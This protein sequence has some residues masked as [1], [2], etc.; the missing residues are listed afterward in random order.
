MKTILITGAGSGFGLETA[1]ALAK[2][3]HR[4][5]ATTH[6]T[7]QEQKV[8]EIAKQQSLKLE[9]FTLDIT[10]EED[11]QKI[12][13]ID[14]D[15][16]VN[17]AG[18]GESGPLAEVPEDRLRR[19]FETNVFGAVALTQ[20]ALHNMIKRKQ[21]TVVIVSSIAGRIPLPFLSPYGMTKYALSGGA[22]AMRDEVHKLEPN[23]HVCLVE[24]GPYPTG[25]NQVMH[26]TK[27]EWLTQQ[28]LFYPLVELMKKDDAKLTAM[29]MRNN[30]TIVKQIIKAVESK[31]PKLRYG[32]PWYLNIGAWL[33]RAMGK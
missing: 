12:K 18:V 16:L 28:S 13:N 22:A 23:V 14:L 15:V 8:A 6:T 10:Q 20:L 30:S 29:E 17:N 21:G 31:K 9:T 19:V 3:G 24:P 7:E 4:V 27:Y 2:R 5:I 33:L 26:K 1:I 32:A 25:F 11:R